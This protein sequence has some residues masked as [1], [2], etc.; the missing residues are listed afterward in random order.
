MK[1]PA[2]LHWCCLEFGLDL[3]VR[4]LRSLEILVLLCFGCLPM[5]RIA[6]LNTS[7]IC[8]K[9]YITLAMSLLLLE[10]A[11]FEPNCSKDA[12]EHLSLS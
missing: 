7:C 3:L 4:C 11:L 1:I 2:Q 9:N 10:V 5:L 8:T 6:R 12:V